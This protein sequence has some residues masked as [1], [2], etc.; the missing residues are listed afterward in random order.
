MKRRSSVNAHLSCGAVSFCAVGG[1][2]LAAALVSVPALAQPTV[3]GTP[4]TV[5]I[6]GRGATLDEIMT[7]LGRSFNLH[8]TSSAELNQTVTGTYEGSLK[9]VVARLLSGHNF[10]LSTHNGRVDVAVFD[11][12]GASRAVASSKAPAHHPVVARA[13]KP[14]TPKTAASTAARSRPKVMAKEAPAAR[15]PAPA[16]QPVTDPAAPLIR[17]ADGSGTVAPPMAVQ[18]GGQGPE[19]R[20]SKIEPPTLT[21][22]SAADV[23]MAKPTS[24]GADFPHAAKPAGNEAP[25]AKSTDGKPPS[26]K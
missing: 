13:A 20:P 3:E 22:S 19:L 25:E 11:A 6:E 5:R 9:R 4:Q 1:L 17:L 8:F 24:G 7:A 10:I 12:G 21:H 2:V 16:K 23:P 18:S 14:A 15:T 26:G